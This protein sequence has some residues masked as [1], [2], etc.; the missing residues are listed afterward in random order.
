[1][2]S[3]SLFEKHDVA[4]TDSHLLSHD[5]AHQQVLD[6]V[7]FLRRLVHGHYF[8]SAAVSLAR[9]D[10]CPNQVEQLPWLRLISISDI[11]SQVKPFDWEVDNALVLFLKEV[12][13]AES[14]DVEDQVLG[15]SLDL[16]LLL[17]SHFGS[18]SFAHSLFF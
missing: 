7:P 1:M 5:V 14:L 9:M 8:V 16:V 17:D 4:F 12:V 10:H 3:A 11:I 15:Q 2:S 13:F 6:V 18:I